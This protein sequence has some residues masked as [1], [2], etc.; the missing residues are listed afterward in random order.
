[1]DNKPYSQRVSGCFGPYK[2]AGAC[3]SSRSQRPRLGPAVLAESECSRREQGGG[4]DVC[5]SDSP[6]TRASKETV[7]AAVLWQ[8]IWQR[9]R[10]DVIARCCSD[11]CM[12]AGGDDDILF[13][14]FFKEVCHWRRLPA[15]WQAPFP[16]CFPVI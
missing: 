7:V 16:Q 11:S 9:V 2:P 5:C 13:A 4:Q 15:R 6:S 12:T 1:M 14:G 10:D 3:P 8:S